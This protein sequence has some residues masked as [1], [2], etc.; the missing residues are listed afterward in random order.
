M[1]NLK[2]VGILGSITKSNGVETNSEE[3][4]GEL[5]RKIRGEGVSAEMVK[6]GDLNF[7][8]GMN[9]EMNDDFKTVINAV[10][11]ADIVVWATPIHWGMPSSLIVKTIERMNSIDDGYLETG[12]NPLKDKVA[13]MVVVG[14]EDGMQH[15]VGMLSNALLWYGFCLPPQCITYWVG[16]MGQPF[17]QDVEKRRSNEETKRITKVAAENLVAYAKMIKVSKTQSLT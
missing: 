11:G 7:E 2:A 15:V 6:L 14:H 9:A 16:E 1:N 5:L 4:L 12:K 3:L 13:G 8:H 10:L 17:E